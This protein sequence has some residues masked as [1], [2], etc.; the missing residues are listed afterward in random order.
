MKNILYYDYVLILLLI[1]SILAV[2]LET[3]CCND[4]STLEIKMEPTTDT[5]NAVNFWISVCNSNI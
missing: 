1:Q 3:V 5:F 2:E 4:G